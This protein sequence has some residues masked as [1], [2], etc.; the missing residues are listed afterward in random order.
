M[1]LGFGIFDVIVCQT[2]QIQCIIAAFQKTRKRKLVAAGEGQLG[3]SFLDKATMREQLGTTSTNSDYSDDVDYDG[4]CCISSIA[5][6]RVGGG[7][8]SRNRGSA[9]KGKSQDSQRRLGE[10]PTDSLL[11]Y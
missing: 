10:T 3:D 9:Q 6:K 7:E 8:F 11:L 4:K 1:I 2:L 5:K